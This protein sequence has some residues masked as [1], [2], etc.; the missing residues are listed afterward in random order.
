MIFSILP[1]ISHNFKFPKRTKGCPA[2]HATVK[3]LR[4]NLE[5]EKLSKKGV[6]APIAT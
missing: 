2:I 6:P 5:A 1:L 3:R 4:E